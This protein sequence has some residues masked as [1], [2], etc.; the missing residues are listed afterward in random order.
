MRQLTALDALFLAGE[1]DRTQGHVSALGVYDPIT[2]SGRPLDAALI[3]GHRAL[4]ASLMRDVNESF[5]P[6]CSP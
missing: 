4:P 6:P 2:A 3:R 1:N 5:R